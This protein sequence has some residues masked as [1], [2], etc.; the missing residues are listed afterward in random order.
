ML[1]KLHFYYITTF[2]SEINLIGQKWLHLGYKLAKVW[3]NVV[4]LKSNL[5]QNEVVS[6]LLCCLH[7]FLH[8]RLHVFQAWKDIC[9]SKL[10]TKANNCLRAWHTKGNNFIHFPMES[11]IFWYSWKTVVMYETSSW[12]RMYQ[13]HLQ[14]LGLVWWLVKTNLTN[15]LLHFKWLKL[16]LF[17]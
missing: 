5:H 8:C 3:Q 7:C 17:A 13:K 1:C 12:L 14:S 10:P 2:L 6:D 16:S 4:R 11:N 9:A 15:L